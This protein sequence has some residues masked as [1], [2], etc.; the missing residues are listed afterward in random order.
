MVQTR[1]V[2]LLWRAATGTAMVTSAMEGTPG[3]SGRLLR[4]ERSRGAGN[5]IVDSQEFTGAA[6]IS[7]SGFLFVA[8]GMN[9]VGL[10]DLT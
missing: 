1:A 6:T 9:R 10:W 5:W 3:L 7:D 2:F 8:F 4:M